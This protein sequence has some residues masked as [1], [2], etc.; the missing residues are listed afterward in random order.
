VSF[1]NPVRQSLFDFDDCLEGGKPKA[2]TAAKNLQRIFPLVKCSAYD[3]SIP[4]PGHPVSATES[5]AVEQC[6]RQLEQLI[7]EHD[8]VFLLTDTRESRWLPTMLCAANNKLAITVALGFESFVVMRH[9]V[10]LPQGQGPHPHQPRPHLGCYFCQDI[11][12]PVNSMKDRTLDQQCTVTRPGLAFISSALAVE[13]LVTLIHHPLGFAAPADVPVP[14]P[15]SPSL[16]GSS[17]EPSLASPLGL[18]PHSIRGSLSQW[19]NTLLASH[20]FPQCTACS[21]LVCSE[22][23]SRKFEMLMDAFGKPHYLE[24]LTGLSAMMAAAADAE[25]IAWDDDD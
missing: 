10:R 21:Q 3:L 6:V 9:G 13:L 15:P 22:Y 5:S 24:E 20:A 23:E 11:V 19:T 8:V 18:V 4:M 17:S 1:S 14:V 2:A 25:V 7:I 16:A 12:A